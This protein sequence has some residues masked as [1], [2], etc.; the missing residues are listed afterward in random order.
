MISP[1]LVAPGIYRGSQP[2]LI[3]DWLTLQKLGIKYVLDLETGA[4]L[5][6]D[7]SPLQE[8]LTAERYGIRTFSHPLGEILPPSVAELNLALSVI[9]QYQ[10]IYVH[11]KAGVDRTG[12]VC[13]WYRQHIENLIWPLAVAE[14]R[15][16]G[17]HWWY[18]FWWPY[19]L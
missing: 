14:M 12:M 9:Q 2:D 16:A 4:H 5:L 11:C 18:S 17:M 13:A 15:A 3:D 6:R 1:A 7:G 8:A 10:P 19:F